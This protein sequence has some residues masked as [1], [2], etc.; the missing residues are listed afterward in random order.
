[1]ERFAG[2]NFY[3]FYGFQKYHESFP[4]NISASIFY[5]VILNNNTLAKVTLKYFYE[6]F[7]GIK[8]A[9]V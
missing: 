3:S 7:N 4:M 2:I 6:N 9:N 8:T 1:M 5:L